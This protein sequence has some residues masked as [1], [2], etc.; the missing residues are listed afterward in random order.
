MISGMRAVQSCVWRWAGIGAILCVTCLSLPTSANGDEEDTDG[1]TNNAFDALPTLGPGG[2]NS[3]TPPTWGPDDERVT[4]PPT[5]WAPA[6]S[7]LLPPPSASGSMPIASWPADDRLGLGEPGVRTER[8]PPPE[9]LE[10]EEFEGAPPTLSPPTPGT[11]QPNELP[12]LMRGQSEYELQRDELLLVHTIRLGAWFPFSAV[13]SADS[14]RD[15]TGD[16]IDLS[17]DA[18]LGSMLMFGSAELRYEPGPVVIDIRLRYSES[19]SRGQ[20][21]ENLV[22]DGLVFPVNQTIE[23]KLEAFTGEFQARWYFLE[24]PTVRLSAG[25]GLLWSQFKTQL[26]SFLNESADESVASI[27]PIAVILGEVSFHPTLVVE[28]RISGMTLDLLRRPTTFID[29][30]LEARF[31]PWPEFSGAIGYHYTGVR[32]EEDDSSP[33]RFELEGHGLTLTLQLNL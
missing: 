8:P 3:A 4:P 12:L 24:A 5:A 7:S 6:G 27:M 31:T 19:N 32:V 23:L 33:S 16:L 15:V 13:R 2:R 17:Q 22:F 10:G 1:S 18:G 14:S 21:T 28:A 9:A 30:G 26:T 11:P 29:M 25:G 20:A